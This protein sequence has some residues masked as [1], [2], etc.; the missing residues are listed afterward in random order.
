MC[1]SVARG[2]FSE[3]LIEDWSPALV[4]QYPLCGESW[5]YRVARWS[6]IGAWADTSDNSSS[7]TQLL[8]DLGHDT[9]PGSPSF[10]V[11]YSCLD[12]FANALLSTPWYCNSL[13]SPLLEHSHLEFAI[14]TQ[15]CLARLCNGP[16]TTNFYPFPA[17]LVFP[18]P[19]LCSHCPPPDHS[20]LGPFW[21]HWLCP[22]QTLG[23]YFPDLFTY[24]GFLCCVCLYGQ[25]VSLL[26]RW[27]RW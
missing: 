18:I 7:A 27:R 13:V 3:C 22:A 8:C 6:S 1:A 4:N 5:Y 2:N 9:T 15:S 10:P 12:G 25:F 21:P 20:L 11:F 14:T 17:P 24:M 19:V 26:Q 16:L 23:Y